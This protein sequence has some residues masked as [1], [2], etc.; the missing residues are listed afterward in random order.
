[1]VISRALSRLIVCFITGVPLF[2]I[3]AVDLAT[4]KATS[5]SHQPDR[6][7][8]L[9]HIPG[10][11]TFD[12]LSNREIIRESAIITTLAGDGKDHLSA[13]RPRLLELTQGGKG[14]PS[15]LL[16]KLGQLT[17]KNSRPVTED[18]KGVF[19]GFADPM[20]RLI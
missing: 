20:G 18:L 19:K 11:K 15:K 17:G 7:I 8:A 4:G 1:M 12:L 16:M 6:F 14:P 9:G 5:A 3:E 10:K 13:R 2:E